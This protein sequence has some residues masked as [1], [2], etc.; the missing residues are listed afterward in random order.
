MINQIYH[1]LPNSFKSKISRL[2][3]SLSG[4]PKV[5]PDSTSVRK[6]PGT[7]KGGA[8]ISADFELGWA[9]RYSRHPKDPE[10]YG[11]RERENM[12]IILN[13]ITNYKIPVTWSTVGHLFLNECK[14]GD[15]DW[16]RRLPHF[17]DHWKFLEGDWFDCDPYSNFQE[18]P[19]WYAPDL[20][21]QILAC[22]TPQEIACHTFSHIDCSYKN[23]PQE[24]IDDE[25][26]ASTE[27]AKKWGIDFKSVTFPGGTAGNYETLKKYGI[28][29]CRRRMGDFELAYPFR[30]EQGLIVTVTGPA[31]TIKYPEWSIDYTMSQFKNAIN[32]AIRTNT[33]AHFWFHPSQ[34]TEDFTILMPL[35]FDYMDKKRSEGLLWVATMKEVA[36]FI[37]AEQP[38]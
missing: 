3:Y 25:F 12:P 23:C 15:H 26:R 19:A 24:V 9:V 11:K 32:K 2:N 4:K 35:I 13:Q 6:F 17:D 36:K 1:K 27:I 31:I 7:M 21:K 37:N 33:F 14:K 10:V 16:M 28:E 8:M 30:N 38:T 5:L 22:K 18:A 34:K 20:I 29:I